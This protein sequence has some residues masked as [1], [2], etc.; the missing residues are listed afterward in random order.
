MKTHVNELC[1][2]SF[3]HI[4]HLN[5]LR[6]FTGYIFVAILIVESKGHCCLAIETLVAYICFH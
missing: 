4:S 6:E 5:F 3:I 1:L 2:I